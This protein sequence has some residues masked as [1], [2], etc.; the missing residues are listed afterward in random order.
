VKQDTGERARDHQDPNTT[1][2]TAHYS[3][4][5]DKRLLALTSGTDG[6]FKPHPYNTD[7]NWCNIQDAAD[8]L[9][10]ANEDEQSKDHMSRDPRQRNDS[11][12]AT[13]GS[14]LSGGEDGGRTD[15]AGNMATPGS[16][17]AFCSSITHAPETTS[18]PD[19]GPQVPSDEGK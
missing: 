12:A 13:A 6:S 1:S 9:L 8:F 3:S 16:A 18:R 15:D 11:I 7:P 14:S 2:W 4:M 10:S 5:L 17:E 19:T